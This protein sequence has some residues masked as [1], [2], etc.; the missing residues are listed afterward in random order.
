MYINRQY[1]KLMGST[2]ADIVYKGFESLYYF[3]HLLKKY[4]VPF[5]EK[6]GDNTYTFLTPYKIVC[7]KEKGVSRFYEN[8]FMYLIRYEDGIMN[9]E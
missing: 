7:V 1:K 3:T 4:G 6:I 5:N 9:Y 8:K 2:P